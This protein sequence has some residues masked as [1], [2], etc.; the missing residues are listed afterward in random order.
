MPNGFCFVFVFGN[1]NVTFFFGSVFTAEEDVL[2]RELVRAEGVLLTGR[3]S[4]VSS[5]SSQA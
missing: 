3:L 5:V 2:R 4:T 1:N